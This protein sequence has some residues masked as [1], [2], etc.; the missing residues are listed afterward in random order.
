MS[1]P[2][3]GRC[4]TT[5]ACTADAYPGLD[6]YWRE[7]SYA[8]MN[9]AGSDAFGWYTLSHPV[10]YYFGGEYFPFGTLAADCIAAAD[11][12]VY[13]PSFSGINLMFNYNFGASF[14]GGNY[15]TIDGVTMSWPTTWLADWGH[16]SVSVVEHE[17]GHSFGLPHSSGAY[18]Q[19]YDNVWDVMSQDRA[20]CICVPDHC[21]DPVYGCIGQHTIAYHKAILGWIPED[22]K[23]VASTEGA[24]TLALSSL[25]LPGDEGYLMATMPID[26]SDLHFYTV[27]ARS[28]AGYDAHL[29]GAAI[30]IHEV[31]TT[32]QR[33]AFVVDADGNGYT[34]DDGAM[35]VPGEMFSDPDA[36]ISVTVDSA[37]ATGFVVTIATPR[38]PRFVAPGGADVDNDCA[39]ADAPCATIQ[40]AVDA[41]WAGDEIRVAAGAY[42][43]VTAR[44]DHAQLVYL[45]KSVTIRGGYSTDDWSASHPITRTT[46]LDA[47]GQGR[48]FYVEKGMH[49]TLEGLHITG[50]NAM[51]QCGEDSRSLGGGLSAISADLEINRCRIYGNSAEYGGG[52]YVID[53]E[54]NIDESEVVN[55]TG[56]GLYL[57]HDDFQCPGG[58]CPIRVRISRTLVSENTASVGG[59]IYL[60]ACS[61]SLSN[62]RIVGNTAAYYAA[63]DVSGCTLTMTNNVIVD[64]I[65][66]NVEGNAFGVSGSDI[67]ALHTTFTRNSPSA[68]YISTGV[69]TLTNT[70][71]AGHQ[72][73]GLYVGTQGAA[74][75]NGVLWFDN[76]INFWNRNVTVNN[77]ITG[78]P[79]FAADG[80]HLTVG[81]ATIDRGVAT[82]ISSDIDGETRPQGS[83]PDLGADERWRAR[84]L[85]P[86]IR[87]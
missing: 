40:H 32:R 13:F 33:P 67:V 9:L 10:S 70:I 66:Q 35:W 57:T 3:P 42:T 81:S 82:D 27:E 44:N 84:T 72:R 74:K 38:K 61:G 85:I 21:G 56:G 59:G 45:K 34:G 48:V 46:R 22:R 75:L 55:N 86:L 19:V 5:G 17:M 41:A 47:L 29:P 60:A 71:V 11:A 2:K 87:R 26:G 37:T 79:A 54:F 25:A 18:G 24:V 39:A 36:G 16:E 43:G 51:G 31:D 76:H 20:G 83:G 52:A 78:N 68:L 65:T 58:A 4:P 62:N 6:H 7:L 77:A 23:Y 12:D 63:L 49:L 53:G 50:G 1:R 15:T 8:K 28:L 30:I 64:N 14:G 80:Y 69:V 73:F